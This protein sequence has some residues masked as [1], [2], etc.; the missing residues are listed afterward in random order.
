MWWHAKVLQFPE[1][2]LLQAEHV[3]WLGC[4][5]WCSGYMKLRKICSLVPGKAFLRGWEEE[6][7]EKK[8][9][10]KIGKRDSPVPRCLSRDLTE[11]RDF[12]PA[13]FSNSSL[14]LVGKRSWEVFP[15]LRE[16]PRLHSVGGL[17]HTSLLPRQPASSQIPPTVITWTLKA[18]VLFKMGFF[19]P[20]YF[21][22]RTA[23][24]P[25]WVC[26]PVFPWGS[27][28]LPALGSCGCHH[29]KVVWCNTLNDCKISE[30]H[31]Q[32][33]KILRA[34]KVAWI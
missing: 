15:E 8:K 11:W 28:T 9:K 16:E 5:W 10:K 29:R 34:S 4:S 30:W 23:P 18:V 24:L 2:C 21:S 33:W 31:L 6:V 17:E 26:D 32:Q 19:P 20:Q 14:L 3:S 12:P 27:L 13:S 25:Y 1:V 22:F 7:I